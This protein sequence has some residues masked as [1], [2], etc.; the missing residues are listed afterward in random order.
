MLVQVSGHSAGRNFSGEIFL[1]FSTGT[2]PNKLAEAS[3]G[4]SYLPPVETQG[5]DTVRNETIDTLL[6]AVSEATE[7]AILNALCQAETLT[8]FQGRTIE[9]LPLDRV[10]ALLNKYMVPK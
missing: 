10:Q 9:A 1:A 8:G 6:Y 7:E 2:S 3:N 5:V 4:M